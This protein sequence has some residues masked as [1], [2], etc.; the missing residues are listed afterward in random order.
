MGNM[1]HIFDRP[2]AAVLFT[3]AY[4]GHNTHVFGISPA[5]RNARTKVRSV[6]NA[7]DAQCHAPCRIMPVPRGFFACGQSFIPHDR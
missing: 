5:F 6:T 3:A 4:A 7:G 2:V 1:P